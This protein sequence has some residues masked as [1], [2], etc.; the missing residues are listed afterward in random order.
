MKILLIQTAFIGDVILATPIIE[1]LHRFFPEAKLDFLV[2]KGNESLLKNH[3]YLHQVHIW[4]K[5]ESKYKNFY[6]ILTTIRL[7][8]YDLV[9][10]IQRFLSTGILS[11][12]S[13]A[14]S[15]V[16]FRKNP[17]SFLFTKKLPHKLDGTHEVDRN[18]SLIEHLTDDSFQMPKLYPT[19]STIEKIEQTIIKPIA[20]NKSF[21]VIAPTSVW[22][23][24]QLPAEKWIELCQRLPKNITILLIGAPNDF[25]VC[26]NI[27]NNVNY[28]N[29]FNLCGKLNLLESAALMSKATMNYANDSAPIHIASAM[30]APITAVFCSTVPQ[31]GFT[32]L[33]D[34]CTVVESKHDLDCRPCGLHGKKSC[35]KGHF[36]C[37]DVKWEM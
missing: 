29:I 4:N 27:K 31:F 21:V 2:R 12:F 23:T 22:F 18:L 26:E 7:E 33:S 37:A 19:K 25:D 1:K 8:K 9:I 5:K 35:P 15:V 11:A 16:G 10:N 30:N 32:P 36:K 14:K 28:P 17:M 6:K 24:K 13:N 3:P 34:N 20:K